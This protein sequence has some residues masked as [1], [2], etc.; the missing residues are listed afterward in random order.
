MSFTKPVWLFCL[1]LGGC[2]ISGRRIQ[3]PR[4]SLI[5]RDWG[6]GVSEVGS[7]FWR[8]SSLEC[9]G[10]GVGVGEGSWVGKADMVLVG[11][12]QRDWE[13]GTGAAYGFNGT[14]WAIW[15]YGR[16]EGAWTN[17]RGDETESTMSMKEKSGRVKCLF[18][19]RD[20]SGCFYKR[21]LE[22]WKSVKQLCRNGNRIVSCKE[23]KRATGVG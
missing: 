16:W 17:R 4:S 6:A 8:T 15:N 23:R 18:F 9:R 12:S 10:R 19:L 21:G 13:R 20:K 11:W 5:G 3:G 14:R 1:T 7:E 2:S 22:E